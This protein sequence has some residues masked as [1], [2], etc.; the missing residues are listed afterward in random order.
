MYMYLCTCKSYMETRL[1]LTLSPLPPPA[2]K[3]PRQDLAHLTLSN[4]V[5]LLEGEAGM[6]RTGSE[7]C[8]PEAVERTEV[9][10]LN[11]K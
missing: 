1:A 8:L 2:K 4:T 3:N 10:G 9:R 6:F 11:N 7:G 5:P